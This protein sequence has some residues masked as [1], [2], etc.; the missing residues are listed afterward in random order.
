MC[1]ITYNHAKYIAQAIES[2]LAQELSCSY[3]IVIADDCS[4]DGTREIIEAYRKKW[5]HLIRVIYQE[6]N[7]RAA[8][9]FLDLLNA[10]KGDYIGYLEGDDY[11]LDTNKLQKQV[12]FL[13]ANPDFAGCFHDMQIVDSDGNT[14]DEHYPLKLKTGRISQADLIVA[15]NN[16]Q[17][18]SRVF[19]RACIQPMPDWYTP[20]PS[21]FGLEILVAEFGDW[22]YLDEVMSAYR[23]H[24]A[25]T[26]SGGGKLRQLEVLLH[27]YLYIAKHP[28]YAT[29]YPTQLQSRL[30]H[31]NLELARLYKDKKKFSRYFHYLRQFIRHCPKDLNLLKFLVKQELLGKGDKPNFEQ[32]AY[33]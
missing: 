2:V 11:Y 18:N 31:Y 12:D 25:G 1:V 30:R 13:E 14:L 9:N 26:F 3:E 33:W 15:G 19:R 20:Y 27:S 5:P 24:E 28:R 23:V 16:S 7:V 4:S 17:S 21:D 10:A 8:Q 32:P 6:V 29:K 22:A